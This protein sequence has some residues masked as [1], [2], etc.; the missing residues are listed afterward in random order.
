MKRKQN[1]LL[2]EGDVIKIT[3]K[4]LQTI[5]RSIC[6][7]SRF[8]GK[9]VV[10]KTTFD[11]GG[12]GHGPHDIYPNGHHVFCKKLGDNKIQIDFY[13]D[14]CFTGLLPPSQIKPIGKAIQ[15]WKEV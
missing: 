10:Y 15:Y 4:H 3:E 14:G 1:R 9:Y 12:C 6:P 2:R 8:I 5:Y 7:I 13:Q 11:G